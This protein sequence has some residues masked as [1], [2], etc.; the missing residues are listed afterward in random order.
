M[1]HIVLAIGTA[2]ITASGCV[3]YLPAIADLQAGE[4]RPRSSRTAAAACVTWWACLALA[5]GLLLA[6]PA[7]EPAAQIVL[8][9]LVA[10]VLLRVRAGLQSR[11]EQREQAVRWALIDPAPEPLPCAPRPSARA[12]LGWLLVGLAIAS[13]GAVSILLSGGG[14]LATRLVAAAVGAVVVCTAFLLIGL[15]SARR[16]HGF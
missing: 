14:P 13:L 5:G 12:L 10:G 8:A 3:W 11:A 15:G 9:G 16:R 4:D 6:V 1:S 7:W 2:A